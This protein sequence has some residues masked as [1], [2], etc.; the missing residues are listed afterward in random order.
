MRLGVVV[1]RR[2]VGRAHVRVTHRVVHV[3]GQARAVAQHGAAVVVL[4]AYLT[5]RLGAAH[6]GRVASHA[7]I[8]A[9]IFVA[10]KASIVASVGLKGAGAV[11]HVMRRHVEG[12]GRAAKAGEHVVLLMV[13]AVLLLRIGLAHVHT[14]AAYDVALAAQIVRNVRLDEG[15]ETER[16][17]RL[18]YVHVDDLAELAEVVLQVLAGHVLAKA[19]HEYLTTRLGLLIHPTTTTATSITPFDYLIMIES[20]T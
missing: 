18:R 4:F 7:S 1:R 10:R 5:E 16:A 9:R 3:A 12:V 2:H 17:E 14:R 13:V 20:L 6:A 8:S 19:T 11:G 15:D